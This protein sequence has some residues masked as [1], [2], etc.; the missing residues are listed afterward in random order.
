MSWRR[1]F[2]NLSR[3]HAFVPLRVE[4]AIPEG[5]RGTFYRNGPG[6]FD[7]AGERYRH[8]FDGDGAVAAVR[9][10]GAG[11]ARGAVRLVETRWR[12]RERRAGRRLYGGYDTPLASPI[13][14]ILL[15]DVKNPANTSVFLHDRRLYALCEGGRP[16]ELSTD[17]LATLGERDLDGVVGRAFSAHP[18]HVPA[19]ETTYNFGL[20]LGRA[21]QADV[22]ALPDR[23]PARRIASFTIEGQRL[24]HD[25]AATPRHLV[26]FFAPLYMSVWGLLRGRGLV[27]G[28]RWRPER[29]TEIVVV[30]I[31]EPA[32]IVR[33]HVPA[34][35]M[36]HVVNAFE[37]GG[38]I[39][40][41]YVHYETNRGLEDHAGSVVSGTPAAPLRSTLRRATIDPVTRTFRSEPLLDE[42]VELP[43][44]S[45]RVLGA[46]HR[47]AYA[48]QFDG[49]TPASAI[50][51]HDLE[52]GDVR[53]HVPGDDRYPSE[54]VFVPRGEGGAEDDGWLLTLVLDAR[55]GTS[56]LAIADARRLDEPPVARCHFDHAIPFG[57]HGIWAAA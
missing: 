31:D 14:E 2:E 23:G 16:F 46:R 26:F 1:G 12:E 8:W 28:A 24:N 44:V 29:G 10:D 25:F 56:H 49:A 42:R 39:T 9:I 51:K 4:G 41:D 6:R 53:R 7:V 57:F 54:A 47:H 15:G 38:S 35:Y 5:L 34:F 48:V 32:R 19:R 11:G 22:H 27:S 21:T 43:R 17:D 20:R 30:P 13:R 33:F 37:D 40:V 18:H 50:L 45:P 36:E 3:E 55:E 52:T